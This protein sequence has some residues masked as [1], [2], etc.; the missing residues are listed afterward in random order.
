MNTPHRTPDHQHLADRLEHRAGHIDLG[1]PMLDVV[2]ARGR[3]RQH[4]RRTVVGVAAVVGIAGGSVAAVSVLSQPAEPGRIAAAPTDEPAGTDVAAASTV[5]GPTVPAGA[6]PVSAEFVPSPF[7]WNR[8]DP[9]SAE[10]VSFYMGAPDNM[11]AGSGPFVVWSTAPAVSDDYSGV[12]WR[13]DDGLTWEQVATPPALIGRNIAELNG[14]FLTYGT[15][16]A[17]AAGRRSDLAIGTSDDAG[18]TWATTVLPLDTSELLAEQGVT[19]VGVNATSIAATANGVLVSAQVSANVD[20]AS[21]LPAEVR[22][23]GWDLTESGVRVP[24][25]EGCDPVTA[26]TISFG[27]PVGTVTEEASVG[28][29]TPT[30][31]SAASCDT[32]IY[33]WAEL[34]I[35]ERAALAMT[36]PDVRL[37][38]SADGDT[39]TEIDPV[40]IDDGATDVRLTTL[41]DSFAASVNQVNPDGSMSTAVST[42]PDGREWTDLGSAPV[43]WTEGFGAVGDR[44]VVTGYDITASMQMIAMRDPSG[45]WTTTPMDS[46]VLPTDGVKTSMG[47]GS[48]AIGP[49]GISLVGALFVDPVAEIG[50]VTFSTDGFTIEV[51][52]TSYTQRVIDDSTGA[53]IATVTGDGSSNPELVTM[54]YG[55]QQTVIEVRREPGGEVAASYTYD[56]LSNAVATA[57]GAQPAGPQIFLLH[58][59]D[60]ITWSRDALDDIAGETITGTGGI[61]VTDTQVIVAALLAGERNPNGTPKQ[62]LLIATPTS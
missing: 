33:T 34:G 11:V 43:T 51:D 61:R 3:R 8:V 32:R 57:T 21:K 41:G 22:D 16:P 42:S 38:F 55:D 29:A 39:F 1:P 50:G 5:P 4:R 7:V 35:S 30:T 49:N 45:T 59:R 19:S 62:T 52:D 23:L 60:G 12:L 6:D 53:V 9:D 46:F 25:G 17:T 37:F 24:T 40:G 54:V 58:S 20:L 28:T 56:D 13:S 10:A 15:A 31:T 18:R 2:I 44:L 26:T 14:R 48:L 27:G 36:H 47:A